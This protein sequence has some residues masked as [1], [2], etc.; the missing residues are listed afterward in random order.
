MQ[1]YPLRIRFID[2]DHAYEYFHS[3]PPD[4]IDYLNE[5]ARKRAGDSQMILLRLEDGSQLES[6]LRLCKEHPAHCR[7]HPHFRGGILE[8]T[9]ERDLSKVFL[10]ASA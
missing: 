10:D 7:G 2:A 6:F 4:D 9:L 5:S 1:T 8:S 3:F